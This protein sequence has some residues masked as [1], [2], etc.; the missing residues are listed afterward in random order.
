MISCGRQA[1]RQRG[2]SCRTVEVHWYKHFQQK[3]WPQLLEIAG[4]IRG[5]LQ[6]PQLR[7]SLEYDDATTNGFGLLLLLLL[8]TGVSCRCRRRCTHNF[9]K[10]CATVWTPLATACC[11]RSRAMSR[12]RWGLFASRLLRFD[13]SRIPNIFQ[14][15]KLPLNKKWIMTRRIIHLDKVVPVAATAV[16]VVVGNLWGPSSVTVE[17]ASSNNVVFSSFLIFLRSVWN[18]L[19]L[20]SVI[21]LLLFDDCSCSVGDDANVGVV[22]LLLAPR[23][24]MARRC[25]W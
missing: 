10:P 6:I 19:P 11:S 9:V 23:C 4:L 16:V 15:G 2:H 20:P 3:T 21:V 25:S 12:W 18:L 14:I 17:D 5:S 22:K 1:A 7:L 8:S 24:N 13:S